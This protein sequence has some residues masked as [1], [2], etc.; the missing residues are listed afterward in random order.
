MSRTALALSLTLIAACSAPEPEAPVSIRVEN[1]VLGLAI[2]ALSEPFVVAENSGST[3]RL[4]TTHETDGTV[5]VTV[6][7]PEYGLNLVA[8][9]KERGDAFKSA[10][11]GEYNGSR[12]LGTP[13]GPAFTSRGQYDGDNGRVEETWVFALHPAGDSR[14]LTLVYSYPP[15]E[16]QTRVV[17]LLAVVGEIEALA[18]ATE[19][20]EFL[21]PPTPH[22]S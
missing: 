17:E 7:E 8:K 11:G 5:T 10:P 19:E 15:G 6:G 13:N 2:G 14:L 16:G 22:R 18:P 9:V 1:T 21:S 20:S 3:L 12:E 4:E